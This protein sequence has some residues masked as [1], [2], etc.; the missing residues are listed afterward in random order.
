M[1]VS[2][3]K[4]HNF[5][6]CHGRRRDLGLSRAPGLSCLPA[7]SGHRPR[8]PRLHTVREHTDSVFLD[9]RARCTCSG[10]GG[11]HVGR[12]VPRLPAEPSGGSGLP[13]LLAAPQASPRCNLCLHWPQGLAWYWPRNPMEE[14]ASSTGFLTG[15]QE[16]SNSPISHLHDAA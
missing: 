4:C 11:Q 15:G 7:H 6:G 1:C 12:L 3:F 2:P 9:K 14:T 5:C 16:S 13:P 8:F 10:W